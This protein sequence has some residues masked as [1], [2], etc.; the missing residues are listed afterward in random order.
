MSELQVVDET[1]FD[2][3]V[4]RAGKPVLVDFWAQWCP[5]CHQ[6]VPILEQINAERNDRLTVL[7]LN[8]DENPAITAAYRVQA[9]PTLMLF[10][11]GRPIWAVVGA[12]PKAKLL[13][14]LDDA[15]LAA[16]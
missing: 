16:V 13:K 6:I 8:A 11:H 9:M 14:E 10:Q 7:K 2:E 4:L 15:L 1:T 12:R 5:P 3:L